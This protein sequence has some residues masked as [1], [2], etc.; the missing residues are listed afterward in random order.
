MVKV[1]DYILDGE[2]YFKYVLM[3]DIPEEYKDE[4]L[5]WMKGQTCPVVEKDKKEVGAIYYYDWQ[6]WL[7]WKT[8]KTKTLIFD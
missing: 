6:R 8:G 3:E 7:D 4:F 1:Y 2:V 5:H